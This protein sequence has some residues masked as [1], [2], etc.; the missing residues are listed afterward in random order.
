MIKISGINA[1]IFLLMFFIFPDFVTP[2]FS[3]AYQVDCLLKNISALTCEFRSEELPTLQTKLSAQGDGFRLLA[4][5]SPYS[6]G[7]Y[8]IGAT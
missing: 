3:K 8:S 4:E 5:R 6:I 2:V 1:V 7:P